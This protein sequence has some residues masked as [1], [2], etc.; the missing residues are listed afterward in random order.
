MRHLYFVGWWSKF[1]LGSVFGPTAIARFSQPR[2]RPRPLSCRSECRDRGQLE[3]KLNTMVWCPSDEIISPRRTPCMT[4]KSPGLPRPG[5][6]RRGRAAIPALGCCSSQWG[7]RIFRSLPR[8]TI[9]SAISVSICCGRSSTIRLERPDHPY[10]RMYARRSDYDTHFRGP[11][12]LQRALAGYFGLVS[13]LDS[14]WAIFWL[15]CPKPASQTRR[16]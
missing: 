15:C 11:A 13:F 4:G 1:G 14:R 16:V 6:A 8:L 3:E 12:D 10:V 9:I 2:W 7:R 5:C